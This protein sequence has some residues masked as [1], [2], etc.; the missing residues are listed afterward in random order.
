MTSGPR[1]PAALQKRFALGGALLGMAV[2]AIGSAGCTTNEINYFLPGTQQGA[3]GSPYDVS[4]TVGTQGGTLRVTDPSNPG[5]GS[6]VSVPPDAVPDNT[7]I[8]ISPGATTMQP[9]PSDSLSQAGPVISFTP[10]DLSITGKVRIAVPALN[11][12]RTGTL[13]LLQLVGSSWQPVD[14]SGDAGDGTASGEVD[15]LGLF[16][17]AIQGGGPPAPDTTPPDFAG[18]KTVTGGPGVGQVTLSWDPGS[19]MVT[20]TGNLVYYV[21][22]SPA[23]TDPD[24]ASTPVA[25]TDKGALSIIVAFTEGTMQKFLVRAR[26]EAGNFDT[27]TNV[28]TYPGM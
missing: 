3:N 1:G 26:D 2:L 16:V 11:Q 27:N 10:A 23:D 28:V 13:V 25:I 20:A 4:A 7:E 21:W 6:E 15:S 12:P 19:D 8:T 9:V 5:F 22:T 14:G 24:P 18:L 17:A